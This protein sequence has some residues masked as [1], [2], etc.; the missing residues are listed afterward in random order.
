MEFLDYLQVSA[1]EINIKL[2]GIF[3]NWREEIKH[4]NPK[5]LKLL[6]VSIKASEGGKRL[7]GTLVKLGYELAQGTQGDIFAPAAAYEIFQTAILA[8]DDIIDRSP[9][10][11]GIPTIYE[12]LGADHYAI[13]QTICLGDIGFFLAF[14][15]ISSS[16][17]SPEQKTMA[18]QAF[19]K[20]MIDT[21]FGEMLDIELSNSSE[22]DEKDVISIAKYKTA[23][24]TFV[25]PLQLGVSLGGADVHL[26]QKIKAFGE[27]LGIAFQIQDDILGIFGEEKSMGKSI[28]SDISE[29][30]NTLLI[31]HALK[32]AGK[33][34]KDILES[35]YGKETISSTEVEEIKKIF[36]NDGSLDYSRQKAIE[37]VTRAKK[38]IPDITGDES[39]QMV[40]KQLADY[41]IEREK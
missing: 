22:R 23:W 30:K 33:K 26:L 14:Q 9:I 7:R 15:I 10:R 31:T 16:N 32:H 19:S 18:V 2:D 40:L 1:R 24:Y 35:L 17:F 5:V 20:T 41:L 34:Q 8:H 37:Y 21:A 25:G 6:E 12:F 38:I 4:I 3:Q 36:I 11:R 29:G 28:T 13:S 27:N 39:Q